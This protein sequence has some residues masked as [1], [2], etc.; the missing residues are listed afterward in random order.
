[1]NSIIQKLVN[2]LKRKSKMFNDIVKE[3]QYGHTVTD[4]IAKF[5]GYRVGPYLI[6]HMNDNELARELFMGSFICSATN[7]NSLQSAF[8]IS[9][10]SIQKHLNSLQ[11]I[12]NQKNPSD[13]KI[14]NKNTV[15]LYFRCRHNQKISLDKMVNFINMISDGKMETLSNEDFVYVG[16]VG[17]QKDD[18][19]LT[20]V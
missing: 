20:V 8:N 2:T 9:E 11:E 5:I 12:K 19:Y 4:N 3:E 16:I 1:M 15:L 7:M 14:I 17:K 10:N 6:S 18:L 13:K